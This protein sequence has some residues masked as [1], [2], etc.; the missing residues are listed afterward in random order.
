MPGT[1]QLQHE[2]LADGA[3]L[4]DAL[5]LVVLGLFETTPDS[6]ALRSKAPL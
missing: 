2:Q 3:G 1:E 4:S 6:A 5:T